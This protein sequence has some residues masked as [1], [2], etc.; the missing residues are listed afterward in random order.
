V[1]SI[2]LLLK[3]SARLADVRGAR[4]VSPA[5]FE[6]F[7]LDRIV[8]AGGKAA[9]HERRDHVQRGERDHQPHR[10]ARECADFDRLA[11]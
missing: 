7:I 10:G 5:P 3:G 2:N 8:R 11:V 9:F 6:Q 4:A 1:P